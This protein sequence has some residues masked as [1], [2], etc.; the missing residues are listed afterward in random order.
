MYLQVIIYIAV[1]DHAR[2]GR[3]ASRIFF[4]GRGFLFSCGSTKLKGTKQNGP[5]KNRDCS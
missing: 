4:L 5:I 2:D 3:K 1:E